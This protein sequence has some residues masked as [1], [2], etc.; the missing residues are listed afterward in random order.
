MALAQGLMARA[1]EGRRA[2][3]R[4]RATTPT[5]AAGI[6]VSPLDSGSCPLSGLDPAAG[7]G[8]RVAG[9]G[10]GSSRASECLSVKRGRRRRE[11]LDGSPAAK[12][13]LSTPVL[14]SS[15][16]SASVARFLCSRRRSH[17]WRRPS[18]AP[19]GPPRAARDRTQPRAPAPSRA[20]CSGPQRAAAQHHGARVG[21]QANGRAGRT[22]EEGPAPAPPP[23]GPLARRRRRDSGGRRRG[24]AAAGAHW[25]SESGT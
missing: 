19:A 12:Y 16:L 4:F 18:M 20:S 7:A 17:R 3:W 1:R 24:A 6:S 13:R 2:H 8:R 23:H 10:L 25:P 21:P 15:A 5:P 9:R 11:P 14:A 22:K